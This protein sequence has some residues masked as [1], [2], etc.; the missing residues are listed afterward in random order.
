MSTIVKFE[1]HIHPASQL[2]LSKYSKPTPFLGTGE[3]SRQTHL[4][5]HAVY[6]WRKKDKLNAFP[7]QTSV[8]PSVYRNK[9][10]TTA[11]V[12]GREVFT[13]STINFYAG[14]IIST[15][16]IYHFVISVKGTEKTK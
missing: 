8:G 2:A 3:Y 13:S 6:I 4:C 7:P 12:R 14:L 5:S 11:K 16:K 9:N 15:M 10:Q 1:E